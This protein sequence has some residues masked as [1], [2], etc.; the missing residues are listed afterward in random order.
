MSQRIIQRPV[1]RRISGHRT[2]Q[3][4][5]EPGL[6]RRLEDRVQ[7]TGLTT[8]T[9]Q[10]AHLSPIRNLWIANQH[11]HKC[12]ITSRRSTQILFTRPPWM[13]A[14][15]HVL[16]RQTGE[17]RPSVF[18][19]SGIDKSCCGAWSWCYG[20]VLP[21]KQHRVREQERCEPAGMPFSGSEPTWCTCTCAI[22]DCGSTYVGADPSALDGERDCRL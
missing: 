13:H 6:G 3:D 2:V 1:P 21:R 4:T 14:H 10:R 19:F 5:P 16:F 22:A 9:T 15:L 11:S 12:W 8:R 18:N 17:F 20:R 7:H